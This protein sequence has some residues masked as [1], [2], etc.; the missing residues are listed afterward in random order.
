[1]EFLY[2]WLL[3]CLGVFTG[4]CLNSFLVIGS[5]FDENIKDS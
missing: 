3:F 1:M 4:M 2:L 5:R